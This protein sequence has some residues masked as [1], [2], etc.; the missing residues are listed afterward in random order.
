MKIIYIAKKLK[1]IERYLKE[2][3]YNY[4]S[5]RCEKINFSMENQNFILLFEKLGKYQKYDE[6]K[7]YTSK[8]QN[9]N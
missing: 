8:K 3:R 2:N 5:H 9:V 4:L 1:Q 7:K 6:A